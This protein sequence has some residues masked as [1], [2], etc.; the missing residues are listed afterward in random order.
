[1][2]RILFIGLLMLAFTGV[3]AQFY[4]LG[5]DSVMVKSKFKL[6]TV[7]TGGDTDSVLTKKA[8][9]GIFKVA[10]SSFTQSQTLSLGSLSGNIAISGGNNVSLASLNNG[11]S[12]AGASDSSVN[13]SVAGFRPYVTVSG[14]T[15]YPTASGVGFRLVR[16]AGTATGSFEIFKSNSADSSVWFRTGAGTSVFSPFMRLV[17]KNYIDVAD[18]LKANIASPTF[19]GVP[20][21]PTATTGTNTTQIATTAFTQAQIVASKQTLSLGAPAG[22]LIISN[23]NNVS[24]GSLS[25][26]SGMVVN[27][28][29]STMYA[30]A[31]VY[32]LVYGTGSTNFPA[33]TGSSLRFV[34]SNASASGYF[35]FNRG[36]DTDSLLYYR[37]GSVST[38]SPFMAIASQNY[39]QTAI[40][41]KIKYGSTEVTF[42]GTQTVFNLPHGMGAVPAS[43]AISFGDGGNDNFVKSVRTLTSTNIVITCDSPPLPGSQMVYWQVFK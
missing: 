17:S 33:A 34:R 2:K 8:N 13:Y 41:D 36:T 19:T 38:L 32:P 10:R 40:G 1:M 3:K 7:A 31:G 20:A 6:G 23:G 16:G 25:T 12:Y 14:S 24:L 27:G 39:V 9:G 29:A 26:G 42:D 43:F 37:T 22:N 11:S 15:K 4:Q 5:F 18:A 21:A 35:E 28:T 30:T